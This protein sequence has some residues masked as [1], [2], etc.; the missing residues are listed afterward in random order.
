MLRRGLSG[1][2]GILCC[3]LVLPTTATAGYWDEGGEQQLRYIAEPG[4]TNHVTAEFDGSSVTVTD[5]AGVRSFEAYYCAQNPNPWTC[6]GGV[7]EPCEDFCQPNPCEQLSPTS[8][9]CPYNGALGNFYLED[10][11]DSFTF[12]GAAPPLPPSSANYVEQLTVT[13]GDGNDNLTGSPYRDALDGDE[14]YDQSPASGNDQISGGDGRDL[15]NS[16]RMDTA[17][18]SNV[19][20]AGAGDDAID[21]VGGTNTVSAGS[22]DDFFT[23]GDGRDVVDGD[24]G[25]DNLAGGAGRDLLSGGDDKDDVEGGTDADVVK[26][27]AGND[28]LAASAHGGCGG[29]DTFVGGSGHDNLYVWCGRPTVLFRDGKRDTGKCGERSRP[30]K[31]KLDRIDRLKG[32]C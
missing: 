25:E 13:G 19:I 7:P 2:L 28:L 8:F 3:L 10:G 21:T 11:D 29:P 1:A 20:D 31:V 17:A 27:N 15:I 9:R 16:G 26:G 6:P 18:N 14:S 22:G 5:S 4:E 24:A 23:G 32:V 30:A 12:T